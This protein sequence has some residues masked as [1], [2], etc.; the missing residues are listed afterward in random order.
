[1]EDEDPLEV[2]GPSK[3]MYKNVAKRVIMHQEAFIGQCGCAGTAHYE[4]F[5]V[6][7]GSCMGYTL[8]MTHGGVYLNLLR[9]HNQKWKLLEL[10]PNVLCLHWGGIIKEK[11][12][13]ACE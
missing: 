1:V 12:S 8:Y 9:F 2:D 4:D 11:T 7:G 13:S 3:H 6:I 10:H 5:F